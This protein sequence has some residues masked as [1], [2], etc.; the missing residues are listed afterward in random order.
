[1]NYALTRA[2]ANRKDD[3]N[4]E[5]GEI[6][7]D[8]DA[9]GTNEYGSRKAEVNHSRWFGTANESAMRQWTQRRVSYYRDPPKKI[10]FKVD[11]KDAAAQ[12][13]DFYD[14][15]TANLVDEHGQP[16]AARVLILRRKDNG[17]DLSYVAR[18]TT[19]NRRYGFI[20]PNGTPNYPNNNGYAC[21]CQNDGKMPDGTDGY[22]II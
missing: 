4:F 5:R 13:G 7:V 18:T 3:V 14:I 11:P 21:I 6:A 15:E 19:F 12:P 20:A 10:E 22:L 9:E 1:M 8:F 17:G 16:L 2:T